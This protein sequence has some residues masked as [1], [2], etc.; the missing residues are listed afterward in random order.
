MS[1]YRVLGGLALL[2]AV[3]VRFSG[4]LDQPSAVIPRSVPAWTLVYAKH[5]G[6]FKNVP[7]A[8]KALQ[9][10][11][12]KVAITPISVRCSTILFDL[13]HLL[14]FTIMFRSM[15]FRYAVAWFHE[16]SNFSPHNFTHL[17]FTSTQTVGVYFDDPKLVDE[18]QMR[19]FAGAMVGPE[20][21]GGLAVLGDEV[22]L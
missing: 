22:R 4:V 15:M 18:S 8:I 21:A 3:A 17:N 6:P 9:E 16:G 7:G 13:Q 10:E 12:A 20:A 2:L 1:L 5:V 14:E 19:W 11:L